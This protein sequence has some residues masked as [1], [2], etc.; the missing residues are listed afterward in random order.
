VEVLVVHISEAMPHPSKKEILE[1]RR[2]L[3]LADQDEKAAKKKPKKT[4]KT[5]KEN[6]TPGASPKKKRNIAVQ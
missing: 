6:R 1:A 3:L 5:D 2:V 4:R